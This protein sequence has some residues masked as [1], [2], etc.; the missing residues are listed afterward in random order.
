MWRFAP[1]TQPLRHAMYSP[2][3]YSPHTIT[4]L[5]DSGLDA[6]YY[7]DLL[8]DALNCR[9]AGFPSA[10][11]YH[12]KLSGGVFTVS[13]GVYVEATVRDV[14]SAVHIS[15]IYHLFKVYQY[16]PTKWTTY[17]R[18]KGVPTLVESV[19]TG[20]TPPHNE[21]NFHWDGFKEL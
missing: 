16:D 12:T 2:M 19:G 3:S 5:R 9:N 13:K 1:Y 20:K 14:T 17:L 18:T 10:E 21:E 7:Y 6:V 8:H 11:K 4:N 15:N